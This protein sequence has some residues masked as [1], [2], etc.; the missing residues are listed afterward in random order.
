MAANPDDLE[1]IGGIK[2]SDPAPAHKAPAGKGLAHEE[3]GRPST[4]RD[5]EAQLVNSD[6]ETDIDN[7]DA[8]GILRS[9]DMR[10]E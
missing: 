10:D 5:E 8:S 1:R 6:K 2:C 9:L 3:N 4:M 7:L